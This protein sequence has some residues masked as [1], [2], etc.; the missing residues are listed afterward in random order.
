MTPLELTRSVVLLVP[1]TVHDI[2]SWMSTDLIAMHP[3]LTGAGFD[4]AA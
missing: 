1:T 4:F 3:C 2:G